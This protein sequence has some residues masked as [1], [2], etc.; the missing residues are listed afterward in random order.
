[1]GEC[2]REGMHYS[3]VLQSETKVLP[4]QMVCNSVEGGCEVLDLEGVDICIK[5]A[6]VG[7][8]REFPP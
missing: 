1:M 8:D 7:K 2:S 6:W 5:K 4:Q 3:L